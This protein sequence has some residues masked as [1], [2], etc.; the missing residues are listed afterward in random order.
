MARSFYERLTALDSSFLLLEKRNSPLHVA[1]TLT[2]EAGPLRTADGGIDAERIRAHVASELHRIPRYRQKIAW[3]P[4][5]Q[6][7]VWIDDERFNLDYHVRHTS[8]PQP[9]SDEQLKRLS[10]RVM[11]QPLDPSRPLWEMWVVEGLEGDRFAVISKVHHCMIDGVSGVDLL[12]ILLSPT[13]DVHESETPRYLPRRAP[14]PFELWRDEMMRRA[15]LPL[16][17]AKGASA[18]LNAA[19]DVR[20][21]MLSRVR[22]AADMVGATMKTAAETPLN[23]RI[24]P[25]RRLDWL[26]F[27]LDDVK[28]IRRAF[29]CSVNDVVL[30]TVTGAMQRFLQRRQFNPSSVDFR[31]MAPVS[32]RTPE[33]RGALGNQVS[34]WIL[35]LPIGE[36]DPREQLRQIQARTTELKGSRSA[37]GAQL[38]TEAAEWGSSTLLAL[39]ARNVTRILPFNLVVTNVPG[40]QFPIYMAGARLLET[41]PLVP[42][43]DNLGLV[44]GQMSY[45]GKLCWGFNADYDLIPD[46]AAIVRATA[47][48]FSELL[49]LA[50]EPASIGAIA[51]SPPPPPATPLQIV[52]KGV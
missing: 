39:G 33:Q 44:I 49:T 4:F 43:I 50:G 17:A 32:V 7:P 28:K 16:E 29:G 20:R 18:L 19:Q 22:A 46:L 37:V 13:P 36:P 14:T 15:L 25:H 45:D 26:T 42:L 24:S 2:F 3:I 6:R 35:E 31:V 27:S 47:E 41:F 34:A 8:L 52:S 1:S 11:E 51:A 23:D 12:K 48:A 21:D 30:A 9:G 38:L 5:T 10:A 40:P